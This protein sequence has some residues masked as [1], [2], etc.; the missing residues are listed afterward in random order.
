MFKNPFITPCGHTF[1]KDCI[2]EVVNRQHRCPVCNQ[3]LQEKELVKNLEFGELL[4]KLVEAREKETQKATENL[5]GGV[6][7]FNKDEDAAYL[8]PI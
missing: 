7:N 3:D 6:L 8:G 1:C 4:N 2:F 5:V